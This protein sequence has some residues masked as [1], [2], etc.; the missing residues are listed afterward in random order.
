MEPIRE[1][2]TFRQENALVLFSSGQDS[3]TCLAWALSTFGSVETVGF[4][5][6]QRHDVEL[7][8][9]DPLLSTL[10]NLNPEWSKRL[11]DD[12]VFDISVLAQLGDTGLTQDVEIKMEKNGLPNTFVPGRNLAFLVFSAALAYRRGIR[13]IIAGVCETDFSGYPDCRDN[14]I[15]A[16]Q[17]ALNLGMESNF[18]LHT[19]LMWL[20]KH[21]TW[22]LSEQLGGKSLVNLVIEQ[23]HTCYIGN[24][25]EKHP[26]GYGC[27]TCPACDIRAKGFD[28]Y[29][30]TA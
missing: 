22:K 10:R 6:G 5:Y 29:I 27:G 25:T 8:C 11:G 17:L 9:R 14:T 3:T 21:E 24:R 4:Y 13:H 26:W 15:K 20:T 12:H 16:M 30:N 18:V 28:A 1:E 19:P 2:T 7:K 23:T